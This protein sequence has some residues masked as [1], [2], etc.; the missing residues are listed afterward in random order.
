[1]K[2][3]VVVPIYNVEAY[4]HEALTSVVQQTLRDLEVIMADDGW[5]DGSALIVKSFVANDP[6]FRLLQ[7][8]NE[9]QGLLAA[10]RSLDSRAPLVRSPEGLRAHGCGRDTCWRYRRTGRPRCPKATHQDCREDHTRTHTRHLRVASRHRR[11]PH[12]DD[13]WLHSGRGRTSC[14]WRVPQGG[15]GTRWRSRAQRVDQQGHRRTERAWPARG[16]LQRHLP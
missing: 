15:A 4:L 7:K 11:N 14:Q 8:D 10:R 6:R 1:V 2:L 12:R 16:R 3:S 9:G 5:T 13:A